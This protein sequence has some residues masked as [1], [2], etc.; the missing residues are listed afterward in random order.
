M[1]LLF[2][3]CLC[4]LDLTFGF[5]ILLIQNQGKIHNDLR[6]GKNIYFHQISQGKLK[7]IENLEKIREF[8]Y[9]KAVRTLGMYLF[10]YEKK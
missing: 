2:Y 7:I 6:S 1:P 9:V 4:L 3:H 5:E 8:F 10:F